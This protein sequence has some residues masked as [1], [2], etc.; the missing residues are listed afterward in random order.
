MPVEVID[1]RKAIPK[2][3]RKRHSALED[4]KEWVYVMTKLQHGLKPNEGLRIVLSKETTEEVKHAPRLFKKLVDRLMKELKLDYDVFQRGTT[5]EGTPILYIAN[6]V[7][8]RIG[9]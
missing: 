2:A 3:T 5:D 4:T 7:D 6:P 9:Y 8:K 1:T